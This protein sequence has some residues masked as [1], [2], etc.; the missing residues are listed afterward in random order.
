MPSPVFSHIWGTLGLISIMMVIS[1]YATGVLG[2][3]SAQIH[4]VELSEIAESVAREAVE[5]ISIHTLGEGG[6]TYM[7]LNVPQT[8]DDEGYVIEL[9]EKSDGHIIVKVR[10]MSGVRESIAELNLGSGPIRVFN[11]SAVDLER[12]IQYGYRL[13]LP[14]KKPMILMM[15]NGDT[16]FIALGKSLGG[17]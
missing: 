8:I 17:R 4:E 11:G 7:E 16:Y 3:I 9:A 12:G 5:L 6:F 2:I 14:C 10:L 13:E 1:L 15:R